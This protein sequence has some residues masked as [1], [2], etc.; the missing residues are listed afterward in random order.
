MV[1]TY[2]VHCTL[3]HIHIFHAKFV[4]IILQEINLE[5]VSAAPAQPE[6][7]HSV[8][9]ISTQAVTVICKNRYLK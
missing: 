8:E 9:C 3:L 2:T 5:F 4:L 1:H 6:G 7:L